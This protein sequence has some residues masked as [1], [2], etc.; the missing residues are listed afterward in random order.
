[1]YSHKESFNKSPNFLLNT[2]KLLIFHPT[3]YLKKA[4]VKQA[5]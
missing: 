1:M 5:I 2:I 4:K 3:G